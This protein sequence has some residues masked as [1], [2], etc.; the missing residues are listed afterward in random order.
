MP[1]VLGLYLR[2]WRDSLDAGACSRYLTSCVG[3]YRRPESTC[4][5]SCCSRSCGR[6]V[7]VVAAGLVDVVVVVV[8][9]VDVVV[10]V[11]SLEEVVTMNGVDEFAERGAR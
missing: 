3:Q 6:D 11:T 1:G 2:L 5:C 4:T 7:G 8:G 10:L 9:L